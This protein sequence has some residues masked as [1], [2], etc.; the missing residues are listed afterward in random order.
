MREIGS[1]FMMDS[2]KRGKNEYCYLTDYPKRY[3]LSGRTGLYLIAQELQVEGIDSVS[4]PA[5]CCGSM[6]APFIEAG[7]SVSFYERYE[8]TNS[9]AILIMDY[10]GFLKEET[11][12][13]AGQCREAGLR[14]IVDATQTAFSR[15]RSYDSADYIVVSYRKWLDCLCAAVYSQNGFITQEYTKE[16]TVYVDIWRNAAKKKKAYLETSNGDK[17]EFLDLYGKA[18]HMLGEDYIGFKASDSEIERFENADS[19]YIREHRRSNATQL[20]DG[21]HGKLNLLFKSL[22]DEDCPLHVPVVL[23]QEWR[24][25]LRKSLIK[26][27]IYCP[28]HWPVDEKYPHQKTR[29]HDEEMSLICDQRYTEDDMK[30]E[31]EEILKVIS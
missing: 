8:I 15:S 29:F 2:F 13:F 19:Q 1:E 18:N 14:V 5:Y 16:N 28:C 7:F 12:L 23:K 31:I 9:K 22:S 6:V 25:E 17:Q 30:N 11:A 20:I 4:L 26:N 3:V 27:S 10:F 21:L 24:T